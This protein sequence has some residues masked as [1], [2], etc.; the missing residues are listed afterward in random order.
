MALGKNVKIK[1][2]SG[3]GRG[4]R[5]SGCDLVISEDSTRLSFVRK[6][7]GL[8]S[9]NQYKTGQVPHARTSRPDLMAYVAYNTPA[10]YWVLYYFNRA[11][12][13]GPFRF[14]Q[15]DI[16]VLPHPNSIAKWMNNSGV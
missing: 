16:I 1:K 2:N 10:L 15:G 6:R 12:C 7:G 11:L 3:A 14:H 8:D 13:Q 9:I 4:S 5:Y